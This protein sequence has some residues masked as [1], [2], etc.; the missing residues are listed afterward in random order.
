VTVAFGA[1]LAEQCRRRDDRPPGAKL[2]LDAIPVAGLGKLV[3]QSRLP[4]LPPDQRQACLL[5]QTIPTG[6]GKGR[7]QNRSPATCGLAYSGLGLSNF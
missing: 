6:H 4:V 7:S 3:H 1:L 5:A 2:A